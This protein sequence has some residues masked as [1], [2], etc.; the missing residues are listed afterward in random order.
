MAKRRNIKSDMFSRNM[1]DLTK[2]PMVGPPIVLL[3]GDWLAKEGLP[4]TEENYIKYKEENIG[5]ILRYQ[6]EV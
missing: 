6:Y 2:A 3:Y 4:N 5:K 1:T